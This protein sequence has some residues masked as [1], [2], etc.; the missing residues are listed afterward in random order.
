M[1]I[2]QPTSSENGI[3]MTPTTRLLALLALL[4]AAPAVAQDTTQDTATDP[5]APATETPSDITADPETGVDPATEA[6]PLEDTGTE[7]GPETGAEAD[8]TTPS[9]L[10][11]GIP[12]QAATGPG[13][14]Y[15]R[16]EFG[17]WSLRCVRVEE[18]EEPCQLYQLLLDQDGNAV[19]EI[20]IFA[21]PDGG[22]AVAGANF[23]APMETFLPAGM[24]LSV[25]GGESLT[26]P[27]TFCSGRPFS[28]LLSSG[29]LSRI[30]FNQQM[31]DLFKR[32]NRAT[33]TIVPAVAPDQEVVLD[34]SLSG[35]TAGF[36]GQ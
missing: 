26:Y 17:D 13:T 6:T 27:F 12:D 21:L 28:P 1:L 11:M 24:R 25:D 32:G 14:P 34:L 5:E 20:G 8:S 23:V 16:E 29:C 36:D 33:I 35:F 18:G 31:V 9:D 3:D 19:A 10:S 4:A 7:T 15:I 30:G 2:G 22:Q